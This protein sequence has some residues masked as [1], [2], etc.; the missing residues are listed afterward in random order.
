MIAQGSP[1]WHQQ[2]LGK[3]TA[4]RIKDVMAKGRGSSESLTRDKY[5]VELVA[6]RLSGQP[7]GFEGNAS[8]EFGNEQEPHARAA[9][10]ASTGFLVTPAEFVPHPEIEDSGASPDG[11]VGTDGLIEIKSHISAIHHVYVL[12]GSIP[13]AHVDQMQWQ[14]ACTGRKWCDYASWCPFMPEGL[15]L[16]V[17]RVERDDARIADIAFAVRKMIDDV[18]AETHSLLLLREAA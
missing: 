1:E 17:H 4:S 15:R 5:L 12:R 16:R 2:R 6:E 14:L 7:A 8:T 13:Q 11:Y 9:Y 18:A 10:E 3:V